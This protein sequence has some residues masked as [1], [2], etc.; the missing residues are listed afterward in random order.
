MRGKIE[1]T[2]EGEEEKEKEKRSKVEENRRVEVSK[3]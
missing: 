2:R 1:C 3:R